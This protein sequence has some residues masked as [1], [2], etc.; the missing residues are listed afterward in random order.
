LNAIGEQVSYAARVIAAKLAPLDAG[1]DRERAARKLELA[2]RFSRVVMQIV[3][4]LAVLFVS[5]WLLMS[6]T[7]NEDTRKLASGLIGT[8]VGY[9]LR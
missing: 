2:Q 8:V 6:A 3:V 5:V 1:G 9:W 4:S 7:A